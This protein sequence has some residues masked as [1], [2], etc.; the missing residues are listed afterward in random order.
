M[1]PIST[2]VCCCYFLV[3]VA[4]TDLSQELLSACARDPLCSFVTHADENVRTAAVL[5]P[6]KP[7]WLSDVLGEATF[8]WE[9]TYANAS[10]DTLRYA[11]SMM[12]AM[13]VTRHA[14]PQGLRCPHALERAIFTAPDEIKCVCPSGKSCGSTATTAAVAPAIPFIAA[15][16]TA[17]PI[18][19]ASL[20]ITISL[21]ILGLS[22]IFG[23]ILCTGHFC[24]SA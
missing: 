18:A 20:W 8:A 13:L 9:R 4:A 5:P 16:D 19:V 12:H 24:C 3:L 23:S 7:N 1:R 11:M 17:P 15:D 6:K 14:N 22:I 2:L 10:A 21:T